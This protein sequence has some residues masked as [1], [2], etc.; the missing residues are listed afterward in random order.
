MKDWVK[1]DDPL[2]HSPNIVEVVAGDTAPKFWQTPAPTAAAEPIDSLSARLRALGA[3][4]PL[5]DAELT[6]PIVTNPH[7][8]STEK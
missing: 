1:A 3:I 4:A 7:L 5:L 8:P 2:R 6:F